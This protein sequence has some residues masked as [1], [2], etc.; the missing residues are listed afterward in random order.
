[1]DF[2]PSLTLALHARGAVEA[3]LDRVERD[4]GPAR[5]VHEVFP[6]LI[7]QALV[8]LRDI[9]L[10]DETG[11]IRM[12]PRVPQAHR[13]FLGLP[14]PDAAR[15]SGG[16]LAPVVDVVLLEHAGGAVI[17][18]A[19]DTDRALQFRGRSSSTKCQNSVFSGPRGRASRSPRIPFGKIEWL[20]SCTRRARS[21]PSRR[22]TSGIVASW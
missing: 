21:V 8:V 9:A 16:H 7:E 1:M 3:D 11:I 18:L 19:A 15:T 10:G 14:A 20:A 22:S 12:R 6:A 17:G 2:L 5:R 4:V 13:Q